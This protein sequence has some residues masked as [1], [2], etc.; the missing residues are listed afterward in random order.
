MIKGKLINIRI[1]NEN[2]LETY[3]RLT[4]DYEEKGDFFPIIVRTSTET[5]RIFNEDGFFS[6]AGG[7][8]LIVSKSDEILGFVSFFKTT[9]YVSGYEIGYQIFKKVN[10]GKGYTTEALKLFSAFLFELFP[11]TRLQICMEEENVGSVK[12]AQKCGFT[13]E[14]KMRN[15]ML[16]NG[17][18]ITNELY[19]MTREECP[20]LK[21]LKTTD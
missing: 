13:F 18:Y 3:N 12:V 6:S 10:R 16:Y 7:R 21:S 8:M 14:G 5:K 15:V 17:R 11:I 1:L 20:S 2:D 4:N 19:S 9:G